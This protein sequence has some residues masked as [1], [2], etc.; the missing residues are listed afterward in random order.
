MLGH[1]KDQYIYLVKHMISFSLSQK[2]QYKW[3]FMGKFDF[4]GFS[5]CSIS[6]MIVYLF[7]HIPACFT[8]A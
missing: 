5:Q 1:I 3:N 7:S 8:G 2:R 6:S 4:S